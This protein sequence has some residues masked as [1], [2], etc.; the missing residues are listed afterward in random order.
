MFIFINVK[1]K[2]V[3]RPAMINGL[4]VDEFIRR[5][6]DPIWLHQNE[7]WEDMDDFKATGL[8]KLQGKNGMTWI[9]RFS[10]N[11]RQD[12]LT[13]VGGGDMT[14]DKLKFESVAQSA[15][16]AAGRLAEAAAHHA[17]GCST[18]KE[19]RRLA[20]FDTLGQVEQDRIFNELR[21]F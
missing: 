8:R 19:F 4:D 15:G 5:N 11:V 10:G 20:G 21:C 6:A 14:S 12:L 3:K 16:A 13:A 7:M 17:F 9:S 2:R 1:Q 18:D